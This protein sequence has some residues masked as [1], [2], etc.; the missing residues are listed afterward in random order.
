MLSIPTCFG[1]SA[2]LFTVAVCLARGFD[3]LIIQ[4]ILLGQ[5][6]SRLGLAAAGLYCTSGNGDWQRMRLVD[7]RAIDWAIMD[8]ATSLR[9]IYAGAEHDCAFKHGLE[10]PYPGVQACARSNL[11][12]TKTWLTHLK[13]SIAVKDLSRCE[14]LLRFRYFSYPL[15]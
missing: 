11:Q 13:S 12:Y 14:R 3:A 7:L 1:L 6:H 10:K 5:A 4:S 9:T 15:H 2:T 8:P